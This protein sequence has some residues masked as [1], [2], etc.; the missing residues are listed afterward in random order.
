MVADKERSS[1]EV[2]PQLFHHSYRPPTPDTYRLMLG[3]STA[4]GKARAAGH[5]GAALSEPPSKRQR[6]E[7][8]VL[9]RVRSLVRP[10]QVRL[11]NS[12]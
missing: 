11:N 2:K 10:L 7:E 5:P 1:R 8:E 4:Q 9:K 6:T 3:C 12:L